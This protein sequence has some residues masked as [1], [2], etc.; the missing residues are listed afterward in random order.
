MTPKEQNKSTPLVE[1]RDIS[2]AFGGLKAVEGVSVDLYP[3][4]VVGVVGHNGAGKSC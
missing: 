3:G 1:M 2:L 4:E